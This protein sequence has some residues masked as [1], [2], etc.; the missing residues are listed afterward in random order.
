[1]PQLGL[2]AI[3]ELIAAGVGTGTAI[4][5]LTNQPSA[6]KA[7]AAQPA[8]LTAVEQTQEQN[9]E[10]AAVSQQI[11]NIL[12]SAP[13]VSPAYTQM[14]AQLLAGT[15]GTPGSTGASYNAVASAFGLPPFTPA[16]ATSGQNA[17]TSPSSLSDFAE[18]VFYA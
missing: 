4:Y 6:P 18:S 15:T 5:G 12:A 13:G 14:M 2:A 1:M 8:G 9:A 16:G 7:S 17:T 10:K 11:P 3:L